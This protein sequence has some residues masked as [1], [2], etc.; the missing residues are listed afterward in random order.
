[1]NIP[2]AVADALRHAREKQE[3]S[4]AE[5]A[6]QVSMPEEFLADLEAGDFEAFGQELHA[7]AHIRLYARALGLDAETLLADPDSLL[8]APAEDEAVEPPE[9][10]AVEP[11]EDEVVEPTEEE[12]ASEDDG[13]ARA[14]EGGGDEGAEESAEGSAQDPVDDAPEG[15]AED[16]ALAE[17]PDDEEPAPEAEDD[18]PAPEAE[19]VDVEDA[20]GDDE[21]APAEPETDGTDPD[22]APAEDPARDPAVIIEPETLDEDE[23]EVVDEDDEAV[24]EMTPEEARRRRWRWII[25]A[26]VLFVLGAVA[27]IFALPLFSD[28]TEVSDITAVLGNNVEVEAN[29]PEPAPSP[30]PSPTPDRS[31]D[32]TA[33]DGD[34]GDEPENP[35]PT[36]RPEPT[37]DPDDPDEDEG[38]E[39]RP[40]EEVRVQLLNGS[41]DEARLQAAREALEALGYE[42]VLLDVT[43]SE[44]E[45]SAVWFTE[46]FEPEAEALGDL[47]ERFAEVDANPGLTADVD[48]HVVV[49]S[50]FA[51]D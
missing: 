47:D 1:M 5:V 29:E 22:E 30:T 12:A 28:D 6:G 39:A 10:E 45:T 18:Q 44:Y 13:E 25:V 2:P 43:D 15:A 7:L 48:L 21:E 23:V 46:D 19:T 38:P 26:L 24:V 11:P 36:E 42:I 8:P 3:R 20:D 32:V 16:E 31:V 27:G 17:P 37:E 4:L 33:D 35:E 9:D 34:D 49:G 14:A 41:R 40:P 50:D 51:L